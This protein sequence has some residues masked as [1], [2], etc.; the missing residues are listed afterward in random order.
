MSFLNRMMASIGIGSAKVDTQLKSAQL[1]A[2]D[3]V[4]G[5]VAVFGGN[6]QQQVDSIYIYLMTHYYREVN[7]K[8]VRENISLGKYQ[9][10]TPFMLEAG[11]T[12]EFPFRFTLPNETPVSAGHS[13]V[14]I[15]TGLDID[16]AVDP[17]DTDVLQVSPHPNAK[18]VLDAVQNLGFQMRKADCEYSRRLGRNYPFVQEFEFIPTSGPFRGRLDELEVITLPRPDGV[19]V[20]VQVDRRARGFA[21]L[22]EAAFDADETNLRIELGREHLAQG[23]PAIAGN[24]AEI[25]ARYAR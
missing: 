22:L 25:V 12:K 17:T 4:E 10:S 13:K 24:L 5:I 18:L 23:V 3:D 14:W 6:V 9:I 1:R 7:D 19:D 8:R 15:Q 21:G 11:E 20:L 2:G 16:L